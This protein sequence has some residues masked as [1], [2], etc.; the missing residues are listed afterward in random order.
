MKKIRTLVV[1]DEP[2][3]RERLVSLLAGE[4][5]IETIGQCRDGEEA[6]RAIMEHSPDLVFLDVQ[7]P[8]LNGFEVIEAVGSERMPL[9]IFVTAYDQ[10]ALKA[11]QVRAL[12]YVLKPFDRERF[13]EALQ[14]ARAHIQRDETGDLGRRLLA[15]V[16]DL[17]RDQPKTDRLVVK[18]AGRLFF[19]RTDEI[20]WIEAAGNYVRLHVGNTSHLLRETMNAIEG[21]LDP[22][23]FFRI[24]RSRIVNMERIQE[25]QPWLNGEYAV[26]LRTGT[27]LTLSRG[28]REKL[29]ERLARTV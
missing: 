3:A 10:H 21:R 16:K 22:E 2:L 9:V 25:M 15:L 12:D 5:D 28:Y 18:S 11:F 8:A 19:L 7:M 1:D 27:R 24:H 6:V 29:Q 4:P 20:D 14:R 17:R 13:Q 23:K 26:V